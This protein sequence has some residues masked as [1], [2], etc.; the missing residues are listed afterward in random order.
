MARV[1]QPL[2][3]TYSRFKEL[4]FFNLSAEHPSVR[5]F[6]QQLPAELQAVD[7]YQAVRSFLKSYSGNEATF[8][9]YRTHVERMLLWALL[10]ARVPLLKMRRSH[11]EQFIHFCHSPVQGWIGPVVKSRFIRQG[12][13]KIKDT[14]TYLV[15]PDWRPFSVTIA[16]SERKSA[17]EAGVEPQVTTYNMSQGSKSQVFAV[18]GSFFQF[19]IQEGLTDVNPIQSIKQKSQ[20]I[21]RASADSSGRSLTHL[22]WEF[23]IETA[24]QMAKEDPEHE[25]TLFILVTMFSMYLRVSDIAGRVNWM[26]TMGD[27]RKDSNGDW[28]LHVVGKGNKVGKISVKD[29]YVQVYLPRYR[30]HLNLSPLPA[31]FEKTPLLAT[32]KG[33]A[34]LSDRH[35][36]LL[37]QKVFDRAVEQMK[38]EDRTTDEIA[39]LRSASLHWLRHTSATFDAPYRDMKDLQADLR[40]EQMSTTQDVYYN[41]I[42]LQRARSM[43]GLKIKK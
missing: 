34:G 17:T 1:P 36:R 5:D 28:F 26:P 41:S 12:G 15:N 38:L 16:K 27:I 11:G 32:L 25:R 20:Y 43:K 29:E 6:L 9:S 37:L 3:D 42:D 31:P 8:T 24:E 33:R 7:G 23:V 22:Q 18:C 40:H 4:N 14:D 19:A 13:R 21:Q 35:L 10:E 30:K 2:F 39:Q